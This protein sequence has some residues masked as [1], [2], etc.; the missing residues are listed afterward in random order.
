MRVPE[1]LSIT[2]DD[3]LYETIMSRMRAKLGVGTIREGTHVS[4]LIY[5]VL[6]GWGKK[7]LSYLPTSPLDSEEDD[8]V[9]VWVVGRSHE[10]IF[11]AGMIKGQ[12]IVKDGIVGTIDWL[13]D[14]E[15]SAEPTVVEAKSTRL[16]SA[17]WLDEMPHYIAQGA[18]YCCMHETTGC[19]VLVFHIN[20][21]YAHQTKD[22]KK[23]KLPPRAHLR[24]YDV[25]FSE[26]ELAEWWDEMTKRKGI[27]EGEDKPLIEDWPD[28]IPVFEFECGYCQIGGLVN[29]PKWKEG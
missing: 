11:G 1:P 19:K 12:P 13:E 4:D 29:C 28:L 10:D 6:K 15:I 16:S 21:D 8:Q 7:Q 26:E 25:Q 5:C 18:A 23:K 9:L 27:I 24:T 2:H 20:G 17:K 14:A 22:G 3:E